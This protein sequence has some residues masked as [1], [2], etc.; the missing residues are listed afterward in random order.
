MAKEIS[1]ATQEYLSMIQEPIGRLSNA[2]SVFKGFAATIVTGVAALSYGEISLKLLIL[3]FLPILAFLALD[4]YYLRLE[5][6]YRGLYNDVLSGKHTVDFSM[7]LP[8]DGEAIKRANA[9]VWKCFLSPS[10]WLFYPA[11]FLVLII[12]CILKASGGVGV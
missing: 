5:R 3:S 11:M 6:R 4:I 2:A 9:S 8:Q 10:I 1:E 7:A 12:V